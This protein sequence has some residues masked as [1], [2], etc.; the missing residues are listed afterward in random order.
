[1]NVNYSGHTLSEQSTLLFCQ[2]LKYAV[3]HVVR[4]ARLEL[5]PVKCVAD[6]AAETASVI[7]SSTAGTEGENLWLGLPTGWRKC[8]RER[9]LLC[10]LETV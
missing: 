2:K 8:R 4:E 10:F 5:W 9:L 6:V 7:E 1:M 3:N